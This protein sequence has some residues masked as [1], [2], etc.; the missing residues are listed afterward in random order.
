MR[1]LGVEPVG[2]ASAEADAFFEQELVRWKAVIDAAGIK[3][4]H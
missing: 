1:T 4:E 2:M 3:L